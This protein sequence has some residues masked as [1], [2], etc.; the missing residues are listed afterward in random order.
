MHACTCA[1]PFVPVCLVFDESWSY[2]QAFSLVNKES[3][4]VLLTHKTLKIKR[5]EDRQELGE[6]GWDW[7]AEWFDKFWNERKIRKTGVNADVLNKKPPRW[8]RGW[9]RQTKQTERQNII[10]GL[11]GRWSSHHRPDLSCKSHAKTPPPPPDLKQE[12][13]V[14]ADNADAHHR[15]TSHPFYLSIFQSGEREDSTCY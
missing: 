4:L 15:T 7:L 5:K 3:I 6:R 12:A 14:S 11:G 9:M 13:L 2:Q 10:Y 8:G 1:Q